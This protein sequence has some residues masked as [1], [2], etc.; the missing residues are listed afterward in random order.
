MTEF[1]NYI[2]R[3]LPGQSVIEGQYVRL[4]PLNWDKHGTELAGHITGKDTSDLWTHI[5]F[6]PF[7][8]L[9]GLQAVVCY[10]ADQ[11]KWEVMAIIR[12]R[13]NMVVGMASFMRIRPEHGSAEIGCVLFSKELQRTV[14]ATETVY[15]FGSHL[16]D[17][18][19][20]RR[21]EWKCDNGNLASKRAALR[22]GFKS[23]G[24]FKN[25][26][27]VKQKNRDTAWFAMT[28]TD[29]PTIKTAY[30]LWLSQDNFDEQGQQKM[31]LEIL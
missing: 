5:P 1:A 19:G 9:S 28:D 10:V 23:E 15:L 27:I 18:L 20:Y 13:D 17:A 14:E 24:L 26:L 30:T 21:Y 8:D 6:G 11:F 12:K 29:W 7:D 3:D 25:D 4:E 31:R 2:P 22:F 16:F